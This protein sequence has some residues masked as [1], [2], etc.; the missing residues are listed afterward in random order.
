MKAPGAY[1]LCCEGTNLE[2]AV[3]F[4]EFPPVSQALSLCK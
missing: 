4:R 1:Y 3:S 2:K